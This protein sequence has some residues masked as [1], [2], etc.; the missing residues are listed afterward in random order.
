VD[1]PVIAVRARVLAQPRHHFLA[2][3]GTTKCDSSSPG[4]T[5]RSTASC[6]PLP[7]QRCP[8]RRSP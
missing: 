6:R 7:P 1:P 2:P 4:T 8:T 3:L 5:E